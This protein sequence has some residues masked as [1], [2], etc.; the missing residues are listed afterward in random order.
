MI[1]ADLTED[2]L[3]ASM[4]RKL[5]A[6]PDADDVPGLSF[7]QRNAHEERRYAYQRRICAIR[8]VQSR[9]YD[10][11]SRMPPLQKWVAVLAKGREAFTTELL[12]MPEGNLTRE[13]EQRVAQLQGAIENIDYGCDYAGGIALLSPLVAN[14]IKAN[15]APT[16]DGP[17]DP[18]AVGFGSL[19]QATK[20]LAQFEGDRDAAQ[21]ELDAALAGVRA[22]VATA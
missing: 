6:W 15:Y 3:I 9:R 10:K 19:V 11:A 2:E 5:A 14:L 18:W 21:A 17:R 1:A 13:Q 22:E 8:A 16:W 7:N 20:Q 12:A 4:D